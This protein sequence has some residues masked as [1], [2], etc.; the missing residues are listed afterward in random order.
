MNN[1]EMRF[2]V[3]AT[4]QQLVESFMQQ[5]NL[6]AAVVEDALNK[7]TLY[8]K[9]LAVKELLVSLQ[10]H[11]EPQDLVEEEEQKEE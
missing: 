7:V 8:V 1:Y 6:S 11:S 10:Q 5:N 9:D 4:L 2:Q 3:Q